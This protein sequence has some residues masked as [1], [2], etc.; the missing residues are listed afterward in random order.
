M[1]NFKINKDP[2]MRLFNILMAYSCY[3]TLTKKQKQNKNAYCLWT[4]LC[5]VT[6]SQSRSSKPYLQIAL[7]ILFKI[8]S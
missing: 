5:H 2:T 6:L 1:G 8:N 3:D 7:N 4:K